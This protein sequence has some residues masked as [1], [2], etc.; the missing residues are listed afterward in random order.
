[1]CSCTWL[2]PVII[3]VLGRCNSSKVF[4]GLSVLAKSLS[5]RTGVVVIV[6]IRRDVRFMYQPGFNPPAAQR[7]LSGLLVRLDR[8]FRNE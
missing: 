2:S 6:R 5:G 7:F 8:R 1:M 3:T 4:T